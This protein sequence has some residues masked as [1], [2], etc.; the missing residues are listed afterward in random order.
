M[1]IPLAIGLPIIPNLDDQRPLLALR[2]AAIEDAIVGVWTTATLNNLADIR[3][4]IVLIPINT[5]SVSNFS[6]STHL[7]VISRSRLPAG[8]GDD[9]RIFSEV[10]TG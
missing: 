1:K 5:N 4:I 6:P 3:G 10:I 2:V 8:A 7:V 9:C